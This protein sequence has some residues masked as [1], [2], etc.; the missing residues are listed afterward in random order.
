MLFF[1]Q[2]DIKIAIVNQK[3]FF[4]LKKFV[5]YLLDYLFVQIYVHTNKCPV[6]WNLMFLTLASYHAFTSINSSTLLA[7]KPSDFQGDLKY[8]Y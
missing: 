7:M 8:N 3:K 5:K 4:P 2:E 1:N 6:A